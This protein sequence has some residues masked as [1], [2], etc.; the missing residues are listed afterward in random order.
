MISVVITT[1]STTGFTAVT[2]ANGVTTTNSGLRSAIST[3]SFNTM[4]NG[5]VTMT[6]MSLTARPV[7][8]PATPPTANFTALGPT[9]GTVPPGLTVN[10]TNTSTAGS[11]PM[12][13]NYWNFGDGTLITNAP[14]TDVVNHF[15]G[16][17]GTFSVILI[18]ADTNGLPSSPVTNVVVSVT[19]RPPLTSPVMLGGQNGFYLAAGHATVQ[20]T[21]QDGVR[22]T[23]EYKDDLLSTN[24]WQACCDS[25]TTNGTPQITLQDTNSTAG[26][27]QRFYRIEAHYPD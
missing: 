13:T 8:P 25:I 26:V 22:Y 12:A 4:Q 27:T 2:T 20:F 3:V 19:A 6:A 24:A 11:A 16:S 7:T 21:A 9:S 10:F 14:P 1:D 18:V 17:T 5:N 23:L 15:Y